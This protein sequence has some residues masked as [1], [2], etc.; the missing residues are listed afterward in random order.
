MRLLMLPL[1]IVVALLAGPGI[2]FAQDDGPTIVL[3][4]SGAYLLQVDS[5][6]VPSLVRASRVITIG[7]DPTPGPE[8]DPV[9][10]PT[11]SVTTQ[12]REW[13]AAVNHPIGSQALALVYRT[14]AEQVR[15]GKVPPTESYAV[16]K[17]ATDQSL[18]VVGGADKWLGFRGKLGEL[19]VAKTQAGELVHP[20]QQAQFFDQVASGLDGSSQEAAAMDPALLRLI[21]ELVL[22]I[23]TRLLGGAAEPVP[24]PV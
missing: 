10:P 14:V 5:A 15:A 2:S 17:E 11:P 18:G 8:P 24:G 1:L 7:D 16:I 23:I 20:N 13:A 21:V 3:T 6:G 12:V 4:P 9:P 22:A 19:I